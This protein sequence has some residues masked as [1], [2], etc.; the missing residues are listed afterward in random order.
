MSNSHNIF[1]DI[2]PAAYAEI[3]VLAQLV[4]ENMISRLDLVTLQPKV[5]LDLGCGTGH[6]AT[7]LKARY[8][9]AQIIAV[10]IAKPML[11]FAN[12][13][14]EKS[15]VKNVQAVCADALRLPLPNDSVDLIFANL[16][17]PWC[18]DWD[19]L[20]RESRRVL[21]EDGLLVFTCFGPD[22]LSGFNEKSILVKDMHEIGDALIHARFSDPVMDVEYLTLTYRDYEKMAYELQ[23]TGMLKSFDMPSAE[24]YSVTFEV[25]YG[26]TWGP[27]QHVD[28]VA[29]ADGV[30]RIPLS[31]LRSRRR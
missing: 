12:S 23:T 14:W 26:H 15:G 21:R 5:I 13:I 8:P 3:S 7:L 10:D 19:V 1:S 28:Q 11:S 22:T 29:D 24:D 31:H 27:H 6:S 9:E 30:V 18:G 25:V 20:F 16:L 4:G 17:L 2:S